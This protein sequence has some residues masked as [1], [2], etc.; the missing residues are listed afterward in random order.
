[1]SHIVGC[2]RQAKRGRGYCR[3]GEFGVGGAIRVVQVD[4]TTRIALSLAYG[5]FLERLSRRIFTNPTTART[6]PA[7]R[8]KATAPGGLPLVFG[9]PDGMRGVLVARAAGVPLPGL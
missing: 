4:R 7:S 6:A 2:S 1:M 5:S 3:E 9:R 8:A